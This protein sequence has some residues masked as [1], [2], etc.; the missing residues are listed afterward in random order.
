MVDEVSADALVTA[1]V[2][3]VMCCSFW[4]HMQRMPAYAPVAEMGAV[5]I[6]ALLR[7]LASDDPGG[8]SVMH[9]PAQAAGTWPEYEQVTSDVGP[10]WVGFSVDAAGQ[11]WLRWGHDQGLIG[12][13]GGYA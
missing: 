7:N 3:Q 6:P 2:D 4:H 8:M 13:E 1:Y 11:A 5:A 10:G 9:M 12:A